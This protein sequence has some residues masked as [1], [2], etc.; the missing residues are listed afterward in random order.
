[1]WGPILNCEAPHI[2]S[3]RDLQKHVSGAEPRRSMIAARIHPFGSF[4][5]TAAVGA[6]TD[7]VK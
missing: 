3:A 2:S 1:M 5:V 7:S 6:A 4:R